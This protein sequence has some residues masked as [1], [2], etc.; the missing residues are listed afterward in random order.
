MTVREAIR[1]ALGLLS[2]RDR[3]LLGLSVA[4]QMSTSFLDLAG[5]LLL[6]LVGALAVTVVQSQPAPG[7]V[8][9]LADF[10]GLGDL[11]GQQLV[12]VFAASAAV[13]LLTKSVLS[14]YL[15]RRVFIFLANRQA[16]VS[17]RLSKELL[18]RPLTFV[19]KRSSQQTAFALIQGAGAATI[20][21]LGQM[22]IAATE[23]ALLVVL[24]VALLILD[25]L[26]TISAIVF[27]GL[28]AVILQKAMGGWAARIG[29]TAAIADIASLNAIQEA[30]SAYREISVSSRRAFYVDRI[31]KL[32]W[33]AAKV[34]ADATFIGML[35]KYIFEAALVL[36]GFALAGVL[37]STQDSVVAVG[38]LALFLAAG[39]RVMPSLLRLQGAALLLRGAAGTAGPTFELARELDNPLDVPEEIPDGAVVKAT[40]RKGHEDFRAEIILD[41]VAVTYPGTVEPALQGVSLRVKPGES[42]ALVGKS[43]A[44]K[45]TLADVILGVLDPDEGRALIDGVAPVDAV[46]RWPGAV[47]YVPQEVLLAN[48]SIRC[49]VALGLPDD[50]ID[51]ELVWEALKRANLDQYLRDQREGLDT[52]VGEGGLRLSGGQR[53]RLGVA[54]ALYTKPRLLVLDEATSALDAETEAAITSTIQ[55][56]EGEV[57]TVVIAHRLSTVRNVDQML[58]LEEGVPAALGSFSEVRLIV[59]ALDRQAELLGL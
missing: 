29:S 9:T 15:T 23:I 51:D 21:I 34:A 46:S 19:Q 25:P 27:F 40:L 3:R 8:T 11:S 7:A 16:L 5:V 22:V 31:G 14:S 4:I 45:S 53:Q 35:P 55:E 18:S 50:A 6:G 13:V 43:G 57:T 28:V 44:G 26:V 41:N 32:R 37:F 36:G 38:T 30:V 54:R 47:A 59:P 58:Y 12:L 24:A 1:A 33:Q 52:Q 2:K 17:A 20:Q 10:L 39:S 49:N 56:L 42:L 48:G